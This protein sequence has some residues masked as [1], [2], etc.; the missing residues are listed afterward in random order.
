[1]SAKKFNWKRFLKAGCSASAITLM[2]AH[3]GMAFAQE[4]DEDQDADINEAGEKAEVV[5][6]TATKRATSIIDVPLAITGLSGNFLQEVNLNDLKDI[7]LWTPGF[8]G[9]SQ[10]SFID[11]VSV[12][13]ILTNDFGVGG[14]PS[15]GFFKNNLYQGRNGVA[16]TSLYDMDRAE[17]LR[18]PQ[19][20][21]FGRNAIGGAISVFTKRPELGSNSG[22]VDLDGGQRTHLVGETAINLSSNE[23]FGARIAGYY[24]HENGYVDNVFRPM[25]ARGLFHEKFGVRGSFLYENENVTAFLTVEFEDRKQDGTQYR[26]IAGSTTFQRLNNLFGV[27]V[28]GNGRDIDQDKGFGFS[29]DNSNILNIGFE[30]TWD[31]GSVTLTSITGY[32]DHDYFYVED[33][34]GTNLQLGD[35]LQDQSG[36]YFQQ[37]LRLA[38][39]TDSALSWYAGVSLYKENINAFFSGK[40]NEGIMCAYY[41]APY[42]EGAPY[43]YTGASAASAALYACQYYYYNV[44]PYDDPLTGE[45]IEN[46]R[47]IGNY[48]GWAAYV[49]FNYA[50]NDKF[51]IGVGVRFS[52]DTK[53]FS[54]S[55]FPIMSNLGPF[56]VLGFTTSSPVTGSKSWSAWTPQF[57]LRYRPN[58][59]TTLFASATRGYKSGGFGS[60][61]VQEL[62]GQP[63]IPFGVTGLSNANARPDDFDPETNWSYEVG[64][65][66]TNRRGTVRYD[67]N[68]YYY[69]YKDLQL[70][71]PGAGGG[72]RIDNAGKV[73]GWGVEGSMQWVINRNWD[74]RFSGAHAS[75][76]LSDASA[77]CPGPNPLACEGASLSHVPDFAGS[78][79]LTYKHPI[80]GGVIRTVAEIFGQ[81]KT[82]ALGASTDPAEII[83]AYG[84]I[85]LRIG[86]ES[87]NGWAITAYV[88]NITNVLYYDGIFAGAGILPSVWF[89]PSRPRTFGVRISASFGGER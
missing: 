11:A 72:T 48:K 63:E 24:S 29:A 34:D 55:A 53:D 80:Q 15:I 70:I 13:G 54:I 45:L 25:D 46:N 66:G 17:A 38:S 21:L 74:L 12:R 86:F 78:A 7:I 65:K 42:Y 4:G 56:F 59:I 82:S 27:T 58:D 41:F 32:T 81:T 87:D 19:G 43:Y 5:Y 37:E 2:L 57:V 6:V 3:P 28:G 85:A 67:L 47:V 73:K 79:R 30:F 9:N 49:N 1:M 89:N 88:E 10:D 31:L 52:K 84:E 76:K 8:T 44:V 36:N 14:E 83:G 20:F 71:V 51:D 39:D 64:I 62:A 50:F 40:S 75:T 18:G 69:I 35:Y 60:F 16:I 77:I 68:V 33:F 61:S 23:N 26:A 22:Y